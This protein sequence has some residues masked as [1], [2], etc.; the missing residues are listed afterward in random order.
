VTLVAQ[1]GIEVSY[2]TIRC[3]TLKFGPLIAANLRRRRPPPS[4]RW[5]LEEM[6]VRIRGRRM[7]LWRAV[8]DE[9]EV[10]DILVQRRRNKAATVKM[11]RMLLRTRALSGNHRDGQAGVVS[12]RNGVSRLQP[13]NLT[14]PAREETAGTALRRS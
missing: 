6:V 4:R 12:G 5:H 3:W 8:D 13:A 9:G 14:I 11:L 7:F 10:L 1:R 2:E